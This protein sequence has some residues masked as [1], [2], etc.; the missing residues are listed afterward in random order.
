MGD[1]FKDSSVSMDTVLLLL[2]TFVALVWQVASVKR[3]V[4]TGR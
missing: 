1:S 2:V 4:A 3:H